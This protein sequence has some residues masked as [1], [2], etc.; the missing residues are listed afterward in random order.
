[1]KGWQKKKPQKNAAEK[2]KNP[3]TTAGGS[4][5]W[6]RR[7]ASTGRG[8][9]KHITDRAGKGT[10]RL[11]WAGNKRIGKKKKKTKRGT[12]AWKQRGREKDL[13]TQR[14]AK[15]KKVEKEEKAVTKRPA[16]RLNKDN[17]TQK[18]STAEDVGCGDQK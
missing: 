12:N 10:S 5:L 2:K 6:G 14:Y 16:A 3:G 15:K 18:N 11:S 9:S 1:V 7:R 13:R 17:A 8:L 4:A